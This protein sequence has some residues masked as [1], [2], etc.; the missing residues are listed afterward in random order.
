MFIIGQPFSPVCLVICES[1]V[2]YGKK[3]FIP[4]LEHEKKNS[5]YIRV[6][7]PNIF[8]SGFSGLDVGEGKRRFPP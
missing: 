3:Y 4:L 8:G 1:C 2:F 7:V 6:F 5:K